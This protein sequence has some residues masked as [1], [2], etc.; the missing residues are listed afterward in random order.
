LV[1]RE[2]ALDVAKDTPL[3]GRLVEKVVVQ[4]RFNH[5]PRFLQRASNDDGQRC[6]VRVVFPHI[7]AGEGDGKVSHADKLRPAWW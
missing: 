7:S 3:E 5:R 1:R 4:D 2:K 6:R